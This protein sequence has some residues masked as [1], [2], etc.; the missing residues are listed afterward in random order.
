MVRPAYAGDDIVCS[1]WKQRGG[2]TS[3]GCSDPIKLFFQI[4]IN[5]IRGEIVAIVKIGIYCIENLFNSK[6]YFGQ[7]IDVD[8][9]LNKH[10]SLLKNGKHNNEHL[11]NAYDTYGYDN[12]KFYIV[13]ECDVDILDER[14]RYYIALHKTDNRSYGY[15]IEPGGNKNKSLSDETKQKLRIANLGK[16]LSDEVKTKISI[17]NTGKTIS[18]EQRQLLRDLHIGSH[19]SDETKA[20]IGFASRRENRSE[21]TLAKLRESHKRENLSDETLQRMSNAH[22]GFKHSDETKEKLRLAFQNREFTDEWKKKISE[23]KKLP[24]YCP[25][26][27]EIFASAKEAEEKYKSYGVNRTKISACLHGKRKSSG[28]HPVTGE[29]LTWENLKE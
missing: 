4:Y 12:F 14:E 9:R 20:K 10:K 13:E 19:L 8:S 27:N 2:L 15:N 5:F 22:R 3:T 26:L 7:S 23:V 18:D 29:S 11:Q 17:S 16:K 25:Q 6:K 21:E 28:K 1:L 24:I